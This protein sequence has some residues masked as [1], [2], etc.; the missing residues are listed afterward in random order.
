VS[1]VGVVEPWAPFF[2]SYPVSSGE[3]IHNVFYDHEPRLTFYTRYGEVFSMAC[4]AVAIGVLAMVAVKRR[5]TLKHST[6]NAQH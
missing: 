4:G 2:T 5:R 6:S 3:A 1:P